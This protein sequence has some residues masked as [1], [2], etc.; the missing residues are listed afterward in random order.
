MERLIEKDLS[1]W[2]ES[3]DRKPLVLFGARQVGKS[4][5]LTEFGAREYGDVAYFFFENNPR[6]QSLFDRGVEDAHSLVEDLSAYSGRAISP[7]S[8]LIIF[9]E[10]QACGA[11][12]SSLKRFCEDAPEYHVACAGSALGLAL[13][14]GGFSFPVGKADAMHMRPMSFEESLSALGNAPLLDAIRDGFESDSPLPPALH[15]KAMEAYRRYLVVGGMPEAVKTYAERGDLMLVKAKQMSILDAYATDMGKHSTPQEANRTRAAY[16]SLPF[17]LAKENRRFQYNLI[18]SGAR[19]KEYEGSLEWLKTAGIALECRKTQGKAPLSFYSDPLS[20]KVYMSDVGLL[21]AKGDFI[22]SSIIS[23][24]GMGGE[25]RGALAEN[26]VAQE[27]A[28]GGRDLYYWESEGRAEVDFVIQGERGAIPV[29]VK[30]AE[31][32][33]S[34]SLGVFRDTYSPEYSI[35]VSGRNFGF[36]NGIKSVPLYAAW[37]LRLLPGARRPAW[38]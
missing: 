33:R 34:R 31:N 29:E 10:I 32:T 8:T 36:E 20:Y 30:A 28:A 4:H 16:N 27:I 15:S 24:A 38:G 1:R 17:Q 7:G 13:E 12:L 25:A 3:P 21:A 19:A 23:D 2:R 35:R 22:P 9:D 6:L 37:C 11:A 26:Y 18:K 5:T 14:R